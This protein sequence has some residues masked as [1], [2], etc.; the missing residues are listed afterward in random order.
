MVDQAQITPTNGRTELPPRAVAR[1]TAELLYDAVT[2]AELQGKLA[3]I[4]LRE[5]TAA[6]LTPVASLCLGI[7]IAIGCVP[8]ALTALA[9]LLKE[10]TTL[11]LA[12]CF[13]ISLAVG[14]F[15]AVVLT[16]VAFGVVKGGLHMFDRSQSEWER[17]RQWF[18]DTLKR[19][20][21]S[22]RSGPSPPERRW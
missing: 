16:I 8:V 12:A 1:N 7:A 14:L 22:T 3:V 9:L 5:G 15:A 10:I 19:I 20:G 17:N 6:L 11:S 18:K 21:Q 4:D 13:G 2:L